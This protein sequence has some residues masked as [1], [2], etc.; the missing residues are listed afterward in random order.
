M[1]ILNEHYNLAHLLLGQLIMDSRCPVTDARG[2]ESI[3][4][5]KEGLSPG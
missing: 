4:S 3:P 2:R 1:A 5:E